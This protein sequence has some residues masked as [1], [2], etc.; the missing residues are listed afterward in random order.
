MQPDAVDGPH[1]RADAKQEE[2]PNGSR[3]TKWVL[4][5]EPE[6]IGFEIAGICQPMFNDSKKTGKGTSS[7]H[8]FLS[9]IQQCLKNRILYVGQD[10]RIVVP[11]EDV[12]QYERL[13]KQS[14]EG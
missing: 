6:K 9:G 12:N 2:M 11:E 7:A 4:V 10:I 13:D 3:K 14:P 5:S 1:W 8:I